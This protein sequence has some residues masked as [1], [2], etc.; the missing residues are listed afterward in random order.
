MEAFVKAEKYAQ[1]YSPQNSQKMELLRAKRG[2]GYIL[3]EQMKFDE[4]ENKY[5]ECLEI[6]KNDKKSLIELQYIKKLRNK[7]KH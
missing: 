5:L 1:T 2:V 7:A 3:I 6:D 4:A